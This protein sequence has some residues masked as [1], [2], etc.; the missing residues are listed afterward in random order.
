MKKLSFKSKI[1]S[2]MLCLT[3]IFA[4]I[5][6]PVTFGAELENLIPNGTFDN[7]IS[8]WTLYTSSWGSLALNEAEKCA[9]FTKISQSSGPE[10]YTDAIKVDSGDNLTLS[11]DY[12][13]SVALTGTATSVF[14]YAYTSDFVAN[15][16][17]KTFRPTGSDYIYEFVD[18]TIDWQTKQISY[19]VPDGYEYV[20]VKMAFRGAVAANTVF[21]IDNVELY[22]IDENYV[23]GQIEK[24]LKNNDQTAFETWIADSVLGIENLDAEKY[25]DYFSA[26][27]NKNEITKAVIQS[28]VDSFVIILPQS[29]ISNGTFDTGIGGWK[30]QT[31]SWGEMAW[32]EEN[33]AITLKKI[34]A[35]SGPEIYTEALKVESGDRLYLNYDYKTSAALTGTATSVYIYAYT[36][37]FVE[38]KGTTSF[39]R[40]GNV[41]TYEFVDTLTDWQT[42]QISYTVPEGY[43]YVQVIFA[44]RGAV[45]VD[46]VFSLDNVE[47][48]KVDEIYV[49]NEI[50]NAI[51]DDDQT[52]FETWLG[53]SAL[54][55]KNLSVNKYADYF[56]A[57]KNETLITKETVQTVVDSL[58]Y[59]VPKSIIPNGTFDTDINGWTINSISYGEISWNDVNKAL[60]FRNIKSGPLIFTEA[61][62]VPDGSRLSFNCDYKTSVAITDVNQAI[63]IYF[64]AYTSEYVESK[65]TTLFSPNT[66]YG[67]YNGEFVLCD[68]DWQ[69]KQLS[70]T[71]PEGYEYV[72]VRFA[73]RGASPAET[74]LSIDNIE[75]FVIDENYVI[76]EIKKSVES[77]DLSL[78]NAWVGDTALDIKNLNAEIYEDYFEALKNE[79]IITKE[80]IQAVVDSFI[81]DG[82]SSILPNGTFDKNI[83]GWTSNSSALAWDSTEKAIT[84]TKKS[85]NNEFWS[86][87]FPV[88]AGQEVYFEYDIKTS[89]ALSGMAT[90]FIYAYDDAGKSVYT[91]E[92][93]DTTTNWISKKLS[94]TVPNGYTSV[95]IRF[96]FRGATPTDTVLYVDNA[97]LYKVDAEY[98][99]YKITKV[100]ENDDRLALGDWLQ[101]PV[102]ALENVIVNNRRSYLTEIKKETETLTRQRLQEIVNT[103]NDESENVS[104]LQNGNFDTSVSPWRA[105]DNS[106]PTV[107]YSSDGGGSALLTKQSG[108]MTMMLS[109][110]IDVAY[111]DILHL[112]FTAKSNVNN[113]QLT[114]TNSQFTEE[115]LRNYGEAAG[116]SGKEANSKIFETFNITTT[117]ESYVA[118]I[119][120]G[121]NIYGLVVA[122]SLENGNA[123]DMIYIDN[124]SISHGT[125][126][127]VNSKLNLAI[128]NTD[129]ESFKR[130][131]KHKNS[132]VVYEKMKVDE[133]FMKN[134]KAAKDE[135]GMNL[136]AEEISA[137]SE[138]QVTD[139]DSRLELFVDDTLI[140]TKNTTADLVSMTPKFEEQALNLSGGFVCDNIA[141]SNYNGSF[142]FS[143]ITEDTRPW[144]SLGSTFGNVIKAGD[145]YFYYY[146]GVDDE[147]TTV[148]RYVNGAS[149]HGDC[150]ATYLNVCLAV[151]DDGVNW[152]R[153]DFNLYDFE[154]EGEKL[155]NNIIIGNIPEK[156]EGRHLS[157][158]SVF[159]DESP[160]ANPEKPYKAMM[161]TVMARGWGFD[162][163]AFESADGIHWDLM[164][165]G[166]PVITNGRSDI[167]DSMNVVL[168]SEE[169]Q[170]YKMYFRMWQD[171][172]EYGQQRA[173][174]TISSKDF[175]NWTS[176]DTESQFLDYYS[177]MTDEELI[178]RNEGYDGD[179]PDS[180]Q[181]YTN[182]IQTYDRAPHIYIG[183]PTRYLGDSTG[184][185]VAPCLVAS[186][187]GQNFKFWDN[188][189]IEPSAE[190]DR[191]GNRSNYSVCG[192]FRT[193]E[194]EYSFLAT[195][196]FKDS[197]C[198]IDRFSFRV[199][200]FV[201]A[202]GDDD[203]KK[204]VTTPIT[205][206]GGKLILN[207]KAPN[208]TVRAQLTDINGNALEGFTYDDCTALTGDEIEAELK[209]NGDLS[210][211]DQPVKISFELTNA[212]LYSYKFACTDHKYD[213]AYDTECN[214]DN[215][216]HIREI[217]DVNGD[218]DYDVRDLVYVSENMKVDA[219]YEQDADKD[220]DKDIDEN[221][222]DIIRKEI[223][224]G[225]L[226]YP[227]L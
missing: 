149:Q 122:L 143:K 72:Q 111:G 50:R 162:L 218:G 133:E 5:Q 117:A 95:Q 227:K 37:D 198:I 6:I 46:T 155:S 188:L 163:F 196:G 131:M 225:K 170:E 110:V 87:K 217:G 210:S 209:W 47:L 141:A 177:D 25:S 215:C 221:D 208:G 140:D 114:F 118:D 181:L 201:A 88:D 41:Y 56:E 94:Y 167:M 223:L 83:D 102:L 30:L 216:G 190:L 176:I 161:V 172:T 112:E 166:E 147:V 184:H 191:D 125:A 28:V 202:K 115:E 153:P 26:L 93:V 75:L 7:D 20:Q 84:L 16:D 24:A 77:E 96:S 211:I 79:E 174:A 33:K 69:N 64:F 139:I 189:L 207:Y 195:R 44:F 81:T 182:G 132:N 29:I 67:K 85:S 213:N 18:T 126:E 13:T 73:F 224:T 22:K 206:D 136:T 2:L 137:V 49:L 80:I 40:T 58:I 60:D 10:I 142:D 148:T 178:I 1:L 179:H 129:I 32:D 186:R 35:A 158:F 15:K 226:S 199:D 150:L 160:N 99:I 62:K 187:D 192:I 219:W 48:Y 8:G 21:S 109:E 90:A 9:D 194:T 106:T 12:K 38:S 124:I 63:S 92:F 68:T 205:F 82:P 14:I 53:D 70:Y 19:T 65:G 157:S 97:K 61:I 36:S 31:S 120:I 119:K 98:V 220:C 165:G 23:L 168:W 51:S 76:N 204:I 146:R 59:T 156:F 203:G 169:A 159:K 66:T 4:A 175:I 123:G 34:S 43:E 45:A 27:K 128:D 108:V 74:I 212:E 200:G 116:E 222:I 173:V 71:M 164:N 113:A 171:H 138:N 107:I 100:A 185:E 78:F 144:E 103:V 105:F 42:K 52:A 86:A 154:Y 180:Y 3:L 39:V 17:T 183:M 57:L 11:Y 214:N 101:K 54:G 193:S 130:W 151:S 127:F 89:A 197:G 152:T 134:L 135:K 145:K 121:N 55:I 104:I 91:Y